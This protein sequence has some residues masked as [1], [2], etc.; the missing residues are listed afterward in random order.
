[1][2]T[3][4]RFAALALIA[5][6][7]A[8]LAHTGIG[9]VHGFSAG[10]LHPLGGFDHVLAMVAIGLWAGASGGAM[11]WALPTAFLAGMAGGGLLGMAGLGMPMVEAGILASLIVLGALVA[12]GVRASALVALPM[13]LLF[14]SLHGHAHGS[15]GMVSMGYAA[16]FMLAT[17]A[18][19]GLGLALN[20]GAGTRAVR[21]AGGATAC[22]G[23]ALLLAGG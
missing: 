20:Q 15:E 1:M 5:A 13:V 8:A 21:L 2:A 7:G 23:L 6:P 18:L 12:S 10:L 4:T 16:G 22:A 3:L 9:S 14:G 17:A 19:H 11:R